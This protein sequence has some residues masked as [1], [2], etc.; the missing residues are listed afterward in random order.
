M[1]NGPV[2]MIEWPWMAR[3]NLLLPH[4]GISVRFSSELGDGLPELPQRHSAFETPQ[5][6]LWETLLSCRRR[7]D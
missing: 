3:R 7:H 4:M 1:S 6:L 5:S 2:P